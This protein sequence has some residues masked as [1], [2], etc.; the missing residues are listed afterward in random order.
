MI[1]TF[2]TLTIGLHT[3]VGVAVGMTRGVEVG[4]TTL[5]DVVADTVAVAVGIDV[6]GGVGLATGAVVVSR[7]ARPAAF[8]ITAARDV[9]SF[10]PNPNQTA[11]TITERIKSDANPLPIQRK[12]L[13]RG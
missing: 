1:H 12:T 3:G 4:S 6:D 9:G 10:P 13:D 5:A 7:A 2:S 11:K 8:D